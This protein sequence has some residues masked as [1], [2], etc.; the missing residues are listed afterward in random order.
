MDL[1]DLPIDF[2]ALAATMG[3]PAC[4]I[5]HARHIAPAIEAGIASHIANLIELTVSSG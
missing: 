3:L 1:V 5:D 4:R 2:L